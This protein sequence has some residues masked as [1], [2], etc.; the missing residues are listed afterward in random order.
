[1]QNNVDSSELNKKRGKRL[2]QA[3]LSV[4]ET[5]KDFAYNI[6]NVTPTHLSAM[7]RGTRNITDQFAGLVANAAGVRKEW[8]LCE[9]DF[10]T[11]A[12]KEEAEQREILRPDGPVM[13]TLFLKKLLDRMLASAAK[14]YG[15]QVTENQQNLL[16]AEVHHYTDY[17][18]ERMMKEAQKNGSDCEAKE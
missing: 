18:I 9:D 2:R 10:K 17:L 5:Q 8:L 15:I 16:F 1:M 6:G 12:E 4:S 11:E 14:D 3:V 13:T 7:I